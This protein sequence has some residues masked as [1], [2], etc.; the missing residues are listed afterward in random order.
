MDEDIEN[1]SDRVIRE[2]L[3]V[4]QGLGRNVELMVTSR[5]LGAMEGIFKQIQAERLEIHA[6][7]KDLEKYIQARIEY[8]FAIPLKEEPLRKAGSKD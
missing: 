1:F 5:V 6:K 2:L 7:D 4:F 3:N 8:D